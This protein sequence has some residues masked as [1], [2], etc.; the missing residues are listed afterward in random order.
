M[1]NYE[2]QAYMDYYDRLTWRYAPLVLMM[3]AAYP[4]AAPN[5]DYEDEF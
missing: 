1:S 4:M 3:I 2:D 5:P